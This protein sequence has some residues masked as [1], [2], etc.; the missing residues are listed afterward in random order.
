[1]NEGYYS[2]SRIEEGIAVLEFPDGE[3]REVEISLLPDC[4][5]E[6]NILVKNQNNEFIFDF[7]EEKRRKDR[8]LELQNKIFG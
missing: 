8:L 2:V 4:V 1:M 3:F 6:G 7:E 5:K